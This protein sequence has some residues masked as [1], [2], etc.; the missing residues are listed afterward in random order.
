MH[1]EAMRLALVGVATLAIGI[2]LVTWP[3]KFQE[4]NV[5]VMRGSAGF[6]AKRWRSQA[7]TWTL[8]VI[9][10]GAAAMGFVALGQ[11]ALSL[12]WV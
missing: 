12:G 6:F 9:G 4:W 3:Q 11:C 8:R 10:V 1:N 5:K 2:A 7:T